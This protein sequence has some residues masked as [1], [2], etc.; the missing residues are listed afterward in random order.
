MPAL[1]SA[2]WGQ[3]L[4]D[5]HVQAFVLASRNHKMQFFC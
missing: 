2:Q 4:C 3:P 5:G 1:K